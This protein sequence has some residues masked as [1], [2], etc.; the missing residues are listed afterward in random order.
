MS[1]IM[2]LIGRLYML[3]KH[4]EQFC[5]KLHTEM[6]GLC[7]GDMGALV[8]S[9]NGN[10]WSPVLLVGGSYNVGGIAYGQGEFAILAHQQGAN[11]GNGKVFVSSDGSNWVDRSSAVNFDDASW[12]DLRNI[13]F[14]ND[15]FIASGWY[16]K[17]RV[18][19]DASQTFSAVR[20]EPENVDSVA[21]GNGLYVGI[22][23][24]QYTNDDLFFISQD[25]RRWERLKAPTGWEAAKA[26]TFLK[27]QYCWLEAVVSSLR[28]L[29]LPQSLAPPL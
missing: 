19:T 26:A 24:N 6:E 20:S 25:G 29:S 12:Q 1:H 5:G 23:I 4:P 14:A 21:Y 7:R 28:A 9:V 11:S 18:S 3:Q 2:A 16:S 15:R 17:I 27:T 10:A 22:G 13:S 8:R